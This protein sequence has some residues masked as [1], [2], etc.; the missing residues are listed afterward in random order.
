VLLL[1]VAVY[2]KDADDCLFD[3]D[4]LVLAA[5]CIDIP[6]EDTY[7]AAALLL[8]NYG[9]RAG[10][11]SLSPD[12]FPDPNHLLLSILLQVDRMADEGEQSHK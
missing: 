3:A 1:S 9:V 2:H 11:D 6:L 12:L 8:S 7:M 5:A 4:A 10:I